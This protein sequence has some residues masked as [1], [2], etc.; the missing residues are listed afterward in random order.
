M[1]KFILVCIFLISV[2]TTFSQQK[3]PVKPFPYLYDDILIRQKILEDPGLAAKYV[4]YEENM[5]Q[6][7]ASMKANENKSGLK[8]DTLINGRRIIP[9][10]FHVIHNGGPENIS[11]A[12]IEDAIN[13]MNIDYNKLNTDTGAGYTFPAYNALRADCQIE[14]R[15]AKLD[16][17]GNCTYGIVRHLDPQT[18]YSYFSTMSQYCWMPS[19]Y[20]NVFTV[21]YIY[22]NGVAL[23]DGAFIGGMSPF[24][25]SNTLTQ[26]LTGGDTLADGVLIRHDGIGSIGTAT[27]IGG[28]PINALNRTFTHESGHYFNLYHTFQTG[29]FCVLLGSD[30]CGSSVL[31]C[32]DAVDDTP[33][34]AAATQNTTTSCYTPGSLNSCTNDSPDMPDMIENYMDYQ[35]GFCANLFTQGQ[36][37]R[38]NATM[39]ADRKK[40]WSKENLIQTGVLDTTPPH[41]APIADFI[42]NSHMVCAGGNIQFTDY[43]YSGQAQNWSWT[44]DGGTPAT[45]TVQNPLVTYATPGIYSVTL[46][47]INANGSDSI[48]K[49][50]FITVKPSTASAQ[51]PFMEDFE[52]ADLNN[53]WFINNDAGNAWEITDTAFYSGV[54]SIRLKNYTGN[55]AGSYDEIITP[56]YDLTTLP[57]DGVPFIKFRL[58]YAGR[59]IAA[60]IVSS[61]DTAF[62][63]LKMF[64]ST[65]CGETWQQKYGESGL[66][67]TSTNAVSGSFGPASTADWKLISRPLGTS[68]LSEN[69]LMLKFQF[70]ANGG[71]NLYI[72][73]INI[74]GSTVGFDEI[75]LS[76]LNLNIQP[77]P[78]SDNSELLFNLEI[79][80]QT[81]I[82]AYNILGNEVKSIINEKLGTGS[83]SYTISKSDLGN[84]GVY[85]VRAEFEGNIFV[86]KIVVE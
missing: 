79:P 37:D 16:P 2:V 78:V 5:K 12:Q 65:D 28:M 18:N 22:P 35:W 32:G 86:K 30:G 11:K 76:K 63:A 54:K 80:A 61:A 71:N 46:K 42:S 66:A 55:S 27:T 41:C 51:A 7:I 83:H 39:Q 64:I 6:I 74:T 81:K 69:H 48:M 75:A 21:A 56:A 33:P 9:V 24:P 25:P 59:I 26:A 67:L 72:D 57:I 40:L 34:V 10:V 70:H 82:T 84:S 52:S 1:K 73:D 53:G 58:A 19:H 38:M 3:D 8:T 85:F 77:N 29:P 49:Q 45:S 62:D 47:A 15:L 43:S 17:N 23:P 44:F 4:V 60:T 50:D 36:L 20:L 31:G 68:F 14:F 13:L